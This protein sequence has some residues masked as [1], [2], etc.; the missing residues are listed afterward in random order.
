MKIFTPQSIY[1]LF[2]TMYLATFSQCLL[3]DIYLNTS[4]LNICASDISDLEAKDLA[5]IVSEDKSGFRYKE[6]PQTNGKSII[7]IYYA[8]KNLDG[9][10]YTTGSSDQ[11]NQFSVRYMDSGSLIPIFRLEVNGSDREDPFYNLGIDQFAKSIFGKS[12]ILDYLNLKIK[13]TQELKNQFLERSQPGRFFPYKTND[14]VPKPQRFNIFLDNSVDLDEDDNESDEYDPTFGIRLFQNF[15]QIMI[16]TV[17]Q[18]INQQIQANMKAKY[19]DVR[20]DGFV[21]SFEDI[22]FLKVLKKNIFTGKTKD[23]G[24][25]KKISN[26]INNLKRVMRTDPKLVTYN[27]RIK[28]EFDSEIIPLTVGKQNLFQSLAS[29]LRTRSEWIYNNE[30]FSEFRIELKSS[31]DNMD[32]EDYINEIFEDNLRKLYE[33]NLYPFLEEDHPANHWYTLVKPIINEIFETIMAA[34]TN[35]ESQEIDMIGVTQLIQDLHSNNLS[36]IAVR[37]P[38][39]MDIDGALQE[40]IHDTIDELV[41]NHESD[42]S[43]LSNQE[44]VDILTMLGLKKNSQ[45]QL[46][47][48]GEDINGLWDMSLN[49]AQVQFGNILVL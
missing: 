40:H 9:F 32:K 26:A 4:K 11:G 43:A 47:T 8:N 28:D 19:R 20:Q 7:V 25:L 17:W 44:K 21:I 29:R 41:K 45:E 33:K 23:Q 2:I 24:L 22:E 30:I 46:N 15:L 34:V 12:E 27:K 36:K 16:N 49:N 14:V 5:T 3:E 10:I 13:W 38:M 1:W 37:P 39:M 6:Y 18:G 31:L 48:D 35:T 42:I